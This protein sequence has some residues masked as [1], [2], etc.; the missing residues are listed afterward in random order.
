MKKEQSK[1]V[2][3]QRI[4]FVLGIIQVVL[5]IINIV[6]DIKKRR[7]DKRGKH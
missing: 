6:I 4:I 7:L 3:Y 2:K 5:N 1:R